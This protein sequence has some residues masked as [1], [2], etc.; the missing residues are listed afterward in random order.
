MLARLLHLDRRFIFAFIA[1]AVVAAFLF[2]VTLPTEPSA[3]VRAVYQAMEKLPPGSILLFSFDYGPST[4]VECHPM[5]VTAVRQALARNL[6]LVTMTLWAEGKPFV[7]LA[8]EQVLKELKEQGITKTYGVDYVNLGF[9]TGGEPMLRS[10]ATG[11]A[12]QFPTDDTGRPLSDLPLMR[13][14]KGYRSFAM[15]HTYSAGRPGI[16]EWVRVVSS[17][18][19]VPVVGGVTAVQAPEVYPFLNS[20]QLLGLLGGLRG[21]AE[22]EVL[23]GHPGTASR[24]MVAQSIVHF[25][26][27]G[28]IIF[29]NVVYFL[30]RRRTRRGQ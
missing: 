24:G 6:R 13:E 19:G 25:L 20:G 9:K 30:D 1:L 11:F 17:Q 18:Y 28:F 8:E 21:A 4:A 23:T 16:V 10:L 3:P 7:R 27:A 26:I 15:V 5:A 12:A 2:P 22:Y 14:V 29:S